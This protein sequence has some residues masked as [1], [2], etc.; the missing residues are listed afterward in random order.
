MLPMSIK[1]MTSNKRLKCAISSLALSVTLS[2][3]SFATDRPSITPLFQGGVSRQNFS[4]L[5]CELQPLAIMASIVLPPEQVNNLIEKELSRKLSVDFR[6]EYDVQREIDACCQAIE[7]LQKNIDS[8]KPPATP[9]DLQRRDILH[10]QRGEL[11]NTLNSL[12]KELDKFYE[13]RK[14]PVITLKP[15]WDWKTR[16]RRHRSWIDAIKS[17]IEKF[18]CSA[19]SP[20]WDGFLSLTHLPYSTPIIQVDPDK[21]INSYLNISQN[22][23]DQ[24]NKL[25]SSPCSFEDKQNFLDS[26]ISSFVKFEAE[27]EESRNRLEF[28]FRKSLLFLINMDE[29]FTYVLSFCA[30]CE[31]PLTGIEILGELTVA[32]T[33]KSHLFLIDGLESPGLIVKNSHEGSS[34][35]RGNTPRELYLD[36]DSVK[37]SSLAFEATDE[38]TE[39]AYWNTIEII[40]P[41]V[42]T[43]FHEAMHAVHISGKVQKFLEE[44]RLPDL[45][46]KQTLSSVYTPLMSIKYNWSRSLDVPL[47]IYKVAVTLNF[48]SLTLSNGPLKIFTNNI[49]ALQIA[50]IAYVLC[51]IFYNPANDFTFGYLTTNRKY[52]PSHLGYNWE[53]R[54]LSWTSPRGKNGKLINAYD[55]LQSTY[56]LDPNDAGKYASDVQEQFPQESALPQAMA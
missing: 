42:A 48:P 4:E 29:F 33:S 19:K 36:L 13:Y 23:R 44:S 6:Q 26:W 9:E 35:Y 27:N 55:L 56:G 28:R 14:N 34:I 24:Y 11:Y 2:G 7:K 12:C 3:L 32:L 37:N 41:I 53:N 45:H 17:E 1:F 54:L 51:L 43:V 49:E 21:L 50:G 16:L 30:I 39:E 46:S 52:I 40:E 10:A 22:R 15:Y 8:I 31:S 18:T 20:L 38:A 47:P 25:F 5:P